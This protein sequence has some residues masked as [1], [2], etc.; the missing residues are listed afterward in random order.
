MLVGQI[1]PKLLFAKIVICQIAKIAEIAI[2]QIA[3]IPWV[4]QTL[5]AKK[6]L[7]YLFAKIA[8]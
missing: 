8:C 5:F 7:G 4:L 1:A 6:V 3:M 2:C